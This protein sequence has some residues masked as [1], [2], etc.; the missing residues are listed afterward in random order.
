M[1]FNKKLIMINRIDIEDTIKRIV[2]S[3]GYVLNYE[4]TNPSSSEDMYEIKFWIEDRHLTKFDYK[5]IYIRNKKNPKQ[6]AFKLLLNEYIHN[7]YLDLKPSN[8]YVVIEDF[9]GTIGLCTSEDGEVL[10]FDNIEDA[11]KEADACQ[12]GTVVKLKDNGTR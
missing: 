2:A 7:Y 8:R 3:K 11:Q 4:E 9:N 5:T 12:N 10:V 1:L 6:E